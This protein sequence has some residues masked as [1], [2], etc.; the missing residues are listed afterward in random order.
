M[1]VAP[2]PGPASR[3]CSATPGPTAA[4][5]WRSGRRWLEAGPAYPKPRRRPGQSPAWLWLSLGPP[6]PLP[7]PSPTEAGVPGT[8]ADHGGLRAPNGE[9]KKAGPARPGAGCEPRPP[10]RGRWAAA[11]TRPPSP[12]HAGRRA[13]TRPAVPP[14]PGSDTANDQARDRT[15]ATD[16]GST[17]SGRSGRSAASGLRV[18][19][20]LTSAT[21]PP[22]LGLPSSKN[23]GSSTPNPGVV[24]GIEYRHV[25]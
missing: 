10:A 11:P 16:A 6:H 25:G 21:L 13:S 1:T 5:S 20:S 17:L 23:G 14:R 4:P 8:P 22:C 18:R 7:A 2:H 19:L 15:L 12:Q 9:S 24:A 3:T